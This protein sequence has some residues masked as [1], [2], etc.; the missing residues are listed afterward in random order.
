M[1][2]ELLATEVVTQLAVKHLKIA[3]AE[4]CTGGML[5]QYITGV[6]GASEVFEYGVVT[7]ANAVKEREL[8]VSTQSLLEHGAVSEQVCLQMAGGVM[9]KGKSDLGI[10]ITG[11]AGPL[12]GTPEKPVGT[13]YICVASGAKKWGKKL[14]LDGDRETIRHL[15]VKNTLKLLKEVIDTL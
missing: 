8:G 9:A 15:T 12:G 1:T 13:V 7:Y 10:G 11:I 5:A 3:T 6:S 4:S 2:I 14:E